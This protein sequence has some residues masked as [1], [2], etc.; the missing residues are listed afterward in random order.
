MLNIKLQVQPED[1][2]QTSAWILSSCQQTAA[3]KDC[4]VKNTAFV[5]KRGKKCP[6]T[7]FQLTDA[8]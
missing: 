4:L 2:T 3:I 6:F 7:H 8:S 1:S 5:P